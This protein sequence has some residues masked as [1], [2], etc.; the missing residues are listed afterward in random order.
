MATNVISD[1]R[2]I[3]APAPAAVTSGSFV[4]VGAQLFGVAQANAASAANVAI[5]T[6]GLADLPKANA[7]S[8]S[9]VAGANVH[10]DATNSRTTFSATSNTRIGVLTAPVANTDV[11]VRV[12]YNCA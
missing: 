1:G 12:L 3:T 11:L 4:F 5:V 8:T 9:A 2:I 10:W 6:R 7:V